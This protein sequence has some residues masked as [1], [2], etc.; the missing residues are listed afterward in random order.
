MIKKFLHPFLLFSAILTLAGC[1]VFTTEK[2]SEG[3]IQYDVTYPHGASD[4]FMT[5]LMPTEMKYRFKNNN[6]CS[7]LSAGL[8]MFSTSFV[9]DAQKK[10]LTQLVK[11]MNKK[12]AL[13]SDMNE[14][15][16]LINE[17][18]KMKIDFVN[19]TK[20]VAGYRCKKAKVTLIDTK[21]TFDVYYTK[22][23]NV[24][25]PNWYSPYR[26]ID[27]VLLEYQI[28][29]YNIEMRLIAKNVSDIAVDD[30]LFTLPPDYKRVSKQEMEE[31][32]VNF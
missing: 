16:Q 20:T 18:P 15:D 28:K 31:M 17:H 3:M 26:E 13:V 24:K 8:G 7:E 27:G 25:N 9:A 4:N 30:S 32:F 2:V 23:I 12:F 29:R 11:I 22:D 1:N 19:S 5:S 6:T 14:V 10:T 21:E